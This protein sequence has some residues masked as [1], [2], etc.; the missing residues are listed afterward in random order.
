[1]EQQRAI[2]ALQTYLALSKTANTPRAAAEI[3]TQ[4]TSNPHTSV[5]AELLH[6]NNIQDLKT[7]S[8][9]KSYYKLLEIFAWGTW[10]NYQCMNPQPLYLPTTMTPELTE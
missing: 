1:M 3:V 4:A 9:H 8:E 10:A 5:F 7:S 2:N 6:T